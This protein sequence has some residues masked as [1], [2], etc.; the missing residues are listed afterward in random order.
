MSMYHFNFFCALVLFSALGHGFRP[1]FLL[2]HIKST[3]RYIVSH[4]R[5]SSDTHAASYGHQMPPKLALFS[6][7]P[8]PE[9]QDQA[10]GV[11]CSINGIGGMCR[12]MKGWQAHA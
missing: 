9:K 10:F 2:G 1:F 6:G 11:F 7:V 8:I 12:T 4:V 5:G 3:R